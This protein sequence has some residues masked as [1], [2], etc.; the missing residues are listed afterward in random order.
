MVQLKDKILIAK[1]DNS[2]EVGKNPNLKEYGF[3][4][5]VDKEDNLIINDYLNSI[6]IEIPRQESIFL[7]KLILDRINNKL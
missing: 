7:I 5:Y 2:F 3:N 4:Y 1:S 6:S